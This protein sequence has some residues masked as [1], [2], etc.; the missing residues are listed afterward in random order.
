M[1]T[2]TTDTDTDSRTH[3][4]ASD[5]GRTTRV[6]LWFD[7]ACPFAWITSRWIREVALHRRL[8]VRFRLMS[9]YVLNEERELPDWYRT[10]VDNSLALNRICAA[11]AQEHGEEILAGLYT[12]LGHRI[13]DGGDKEYRAVA[14]Q[15]LAALDLPAGL[16]AAADTEAHDA[17]LRGSHAS[18]ADA[19]GD[20]V[21]TPALRIDGVAYFGPVLQSI[22]RGEEAARLFDAVRTLAGFPDFF[23]LKRPRSGRLRFD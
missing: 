17:W 15:A 9:L 1:T 22:P 8:D 20:D 3:P 23:E 13:H 21:G 7:P 6:D 2:G 10:L 5:P 4:S 14:R 12:E 11:A 19:V 18:C 16:L